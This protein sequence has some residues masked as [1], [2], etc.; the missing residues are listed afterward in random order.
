MKPNIHAKNSVTRFGGKPEDYYH[1]HNFLDST[2][3]HFPDI[4]HRTILHNSWG[5]FLCE[6]VHGVSFINSDNKEV[7]VRDV[8]E[9]HVLQDIG[10]IPTLEDYLKEMPYID[11]MWGGRI[12]KSEVHKVKGESEKVMLKKILERMDYWRINKTIEP[13]CPAKPIQIEPPLW[14]PPWRP[15]NEIVD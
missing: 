7:A 5:I 10:F 1:I 11:W 9:Q 2:K 4:R 14:N 6:Q 15:P 3:A 13:P 12:P 8:A